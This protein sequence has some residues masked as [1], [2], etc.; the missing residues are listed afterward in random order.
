[1]S[2]LSAQ[3]P[4]SCHGRQEEGPGSPAAPTPTAHAPGTKPG[5]GPASSSPL[6]IAITLTRP[7]AFTVSGSSVEFIWTCAGREGSVGSAGSAHGPLASRDSPHGSCAGSHG[8]L[9]A[10]SAKAAARRA[11]LSRRSC[12]PRDGHVQGSSK[13]LERAA[14]CPTC[15]RIYALLCNFLCSKEAARRLCPVARLCRVHAP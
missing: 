7:T 8:S 9:V 10:A 5:A 2:P 6:C 15:T 11:A 12:A 13:G 3:R 4:G 14:G 1:M